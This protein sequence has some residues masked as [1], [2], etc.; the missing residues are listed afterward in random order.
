ME[1]TY[2]NNL[3]QLSN[4]FRADQK[5]K[6]VIKSKCLLNTDRF[7]ASITSLGSLFWC[8]ITLSV[9]KCFLMPSLNLPT[10]ALNHSYVSCYWIP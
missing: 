6:H 7:G 10:A 8:L 9:K 2:N 1:G 5:L 4:Y 3:V